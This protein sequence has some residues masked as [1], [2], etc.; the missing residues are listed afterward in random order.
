VASVA[1]VTVV[2]ELLKPTVPAVSLTVLYILAVLP[3]AVVWGRALAVAVAVL[4][5]VTFDFLLL[6]PRYSLR[7]GDTSLWIALGVFLVSALLVGELAARARRRAQE[8]SLQAR[9]LEGEQ[10]ALRR[11]ATMVA[12]EAAPLDVFTTVIGEAAAAL[13]LPLISMIRYDPDGTATVIATSHDEFPL[14]SNLTLDGPSAVALVRATGRPARVDDYSDLTGSVAVR[15][16]AVGIGAAV[17]APIVVDGRV[18]GAMVAVV[19]RGQPLRPDVDARLNGFTELVGTAVSNAQA[20]DALRELADEQASLRRVATLIAREATP[21]EVFAVVAREVA[22]TLDVPL[23]ALVRFESD[24]SATQVGRFGEDNPYPVGTS[25]PLDGMSVSGQVARTGLPARVDDYAKVPG[26]IATGLAS[27]AGIHTAVGVPVLVESRPWG[28]IMALSTAQRPIPAG[29][30][31]RL[32]AFTELVATAIANAQARDQLRRLADEQA[33]LRRV[34]TLVARGTDAQAVFDAVCAETGPLIGA[35]S[36]NL[37]AFTPDGFTVAMA[38]WSLRDTH[39]QSG[40]RLPIAPDTLDGLVRASGG[41]ARVDSYAGIAGELAAVLRERGIRSEVGAPV[42]VE[43]VTW[44]ALVAG[45]DADEPLPAAAELRLARFAELI[46][47]AVSNATTRSELVASRARIVAAGDE[48]RRRIERNLHDGTQQRLV[49]LGLDVQALRASVPEDMGDVHAE[50]DRLRRDIAA[51]TQDVREVSRG[52]HPA[53]LSQGGLAPALRGLARRSGVPVE[54]E[55]ADGG[56]HPP[57]IEIAVYYVVSEALANA[58][59]HSGASVVTV[60]L[61]VDGDRLRASVADD[62]RGGAELGPGTG[63]IGLVD[64]VEALGGRFALESLPG[65]GT[66]VAIDLPLAEPA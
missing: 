18:W 20:R 31:Q 43:G 59:K 34:A 22:T 23:T 8:S 64:R 12:H 36:V 30:E 19:P 9:T 3:V 29:T 39:L 60:A 1:L 44:G 46:A 61:G 63:L 58:A 6:E 51:V 65:R 32:A 55:I 57:S 14:G 2:I 47:T 38:G 40:V 56:R 50:L 62:G 33:A 17:G 25:W 7:V 13:D 24:G 52:L 41:T 35:S 66:T 11:V 54:L 49:S 10:I 37:T 26:P 21:A 48:A 5:M 45:T 53:V 16:R 27:G 28:L 42:I 4:S 15:A